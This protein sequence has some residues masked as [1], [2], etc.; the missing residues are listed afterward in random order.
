MRRPAAVS[1]VN[2]SIVDDL[3]SRHPWLA[4]R[5]CVV[6][7]GFDPGEEADDV[8]AR[9]RFLVRAHR[10]A[11]RAR[12]A[13]T[14]LP[15]RPGRPAGRRERPVRRHRRRP[16]RGRRR[17]AGYRRSRA[18]RALRGAPAGAGLPARGRRLAARQRTRP[19]IAV[20]QGVRV[21]AVGAAGV[22]HLARSL[23]P[24]ATCSTRWAAARPCRPTAP[25][26]SPSPRSSAPCATAAGRPSRPTLCDATGT[27]RSAPSSVPCCPAWSRRRR[28]PDRRA[29]TGHALTRSRG[30]DR[31]AVATVVATAAV[32]TAALTDFATRG[33]APLTHAAVAVALPLAAAVVLLVVATRHR[34]AR[35]RLSRAPRARPDRAAGPPG[36]SLGPRSPCP[37]SAS[38]TPSRLV[39]ALP[40]LLGLGV[41]HP[42]APPPAPRGPVTFATLYGP[43]CAGC[44][45]LWRG[46]PIQRRAPRYLSSS[47]SVSVCSRRP[48]RAAA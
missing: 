46:R 11:V 23:V 37:T 33:R 6:P 4:A 25:W 7:N 38:S 12:Q 14:R 29:V 16:D 40:G 3:A 30:R 24:R 41:A 2:R 26:R 18:R 22:R 39:L 47:S 5:T 17:R 21:P 42:H 1:A 15:D 10:S 36:P 13:G 19:R 44:S 27:T 35:V 31:L 20:E 9:P 28:R 32:L 8:R 34:L 43:G 48:P 45:S